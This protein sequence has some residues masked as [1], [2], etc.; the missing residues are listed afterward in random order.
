MDMISFIKLLDLIWSIKTYVPLAQYIKHSIDFLNS[1][2][3]SNLYSSGVD[4][5]ILLCFD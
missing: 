3:R 4:T 1:I 5:I 2:E